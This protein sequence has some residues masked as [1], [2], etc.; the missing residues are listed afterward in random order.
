MSVSESG[1]S[2]KSSV[3]DFFTSDESRHQRRRS[4]VGVL[5]AILF[6]PALLG[7]M[8]CLE[9]PAPVGDPEKSRIEPGISGVWLQD[10]EDSEKLLWM[11]EPYDK[12]T[13]LVRWVQLREKKII[14]DDGLELIPSDDADDEPTAL[15]L[16]RAERLQ[17]EGVALF[18]AWRKRISGRSFVTMEVKG[19]LDSESG[20]ESGIWWVAEVDL[21]DDDH[22]SMNFIKNEFDEIEDGMSRSQLE[23]IIRRNLDNPDLFTTEV[24]GGVFER[25]P[26]TEYDVVADMLDEAGVMATYD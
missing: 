14:E 5:A 17:A 1:H 26:Q 3:N 22:L 15:E 2:K 13:W 10:S 21:V 19:I 16:L 11:F 24:F 4:G 12:R 25:V 8:G 9:L 7:V 6:V 20:M 18:K 23:R